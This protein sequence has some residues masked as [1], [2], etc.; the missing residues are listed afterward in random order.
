MDKVAVE[1]PGACWIWCGALFTQGYGMFWLDGKQRRA[2]RVLYVWTYGE[3]GLGDDLDHTCRNRS[4]VNPDHLQVTTRREN[5]LRGT[6]PTAINARKE[7]SVHGQDLDYVDPRGWRGSR[8]DRTAAAA[9]YR[10]A[11]RDEINERRRRNR[12]RVVHEPRICPQCGASFTP[13]RSTKRYCSEH[14]QATANNRAQ[15]QKRQR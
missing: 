15:Y 2:H 4:C 10:E 11:H 14:C 7:R 6:G 13:I 12:S 9:R 5:V 8:K 3:L 1:A